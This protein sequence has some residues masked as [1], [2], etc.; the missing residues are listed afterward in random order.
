MSADPVSDRDSRLNPD[1]TDIGEGSASARN[2]SAAEFDAVHDLQF[3]VVLC[4]HPRRAAEVETAAVN[5]G[6]PIDGKNGV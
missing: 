2:V 4:G 5:D 3:S 6:V 1:Q